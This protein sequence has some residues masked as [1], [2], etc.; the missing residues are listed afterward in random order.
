[1]CVLACVSPS[2]RLRQV[3][4]LLSVSLSLLEYWELPSRSLPGALRTQIS[5]KL[6]ELKAGILILLKVVHTH[7][8]AH[9]NTDPHTR[10]HSQTLTSFWLFMF[11]RLTVNLY[12]QTDDGEEGR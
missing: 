12:M 11:M 3:M 9:T 4:K 7:V 8:S 6:S 5:A 1:M 10:R 2:Y